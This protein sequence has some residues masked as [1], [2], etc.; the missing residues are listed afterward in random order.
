MTC[1]YLTRLTSA[2]VFLSA[3]ITFTAVRTAAAVEGGAILKNGDFESVQDAKPGSDGLVT[4]WRLGSP[5]QMPTGWQLNAAY[6]GQLAIGVD[7][8]HSGS[9]FVRITA[10]PSGTAHLYQM[11][12]GLQAGKWYRVSLWARGGAF[13]VQTY[14]YFNQGP[15]GGQVLLQQS[16]G[17][18]WQRFT[19]FYQP[20]GEGYLRSALAISTS[21]GGIIDVDDVA[22]DA[23]ALAEVPA[24]APDL[25]FQNDAAQV[26][27]SASGLLTHLVSRTSGKDYAATNPARPVFT[28]QRAGARIPVSLLTRKGDVLTAQFLDPDINVSLRVVTGKRHFSLEVLRVEPAD[29]DALYVEFPL[30][31][32]ETVGPAFNA[33][34]D[35]EFGASFFGT[36]ANTLCAPT[37]LGN[38]IQ[39][40][41]CGSRRTHGIAG[42]KFSLVATPFADFRSAIM[43]AECAGGLPCPKH[44]DKWVRDSA[45]VRKSYL[46]AADA[47]EANIDTLIDYAKLGGFGTI[48]FHKDNWLKTHGH[49]QIN[50]DNFPHG[51]DGVKAAVAK[52]HAAGLEAGV[53]VFGP[54]ISS[55]DA[56]ITPKPDDRLAT[57]PGS[58]LAEALDEKTAT[59]TLSATPK[60][61]P[62][63]PSSKAFPGSYLRI[64][65]EIIRYG[66]AE[67]GP[68]F[69]YTNCIRGALGTRAAAHP[70]GSEVQGLLALWGFFLVDP[71]ST[72]ADELAQN[73]ANVF[74]HTDFDMVYFDSVDGINDAYIDHWYYLNRMHLG[75]YRKFKKD[76]LYQTSNGVGWNIEWHIV[77]RAASADGHGDIKG[78]LD[79]RWPGILTMGANFTRPDLGWYYWFKDVR[80]DQ[81]EYVAAKAVGVDGSISLE[82]SRA[83]LE[84]QVQSRQMMDTIHKWEQA[85]RA[86]PFS[87]KIKAKLRE[88]QKDFKLFSGAKGGWQ[89]YRAAYEVPKIVDVLDGQQNTWNIRNDAATDVGLGVE[90]VSGE[91]SVAKAAYNDPGALTIESFENAGEY[92]MNDL[93]QYV[94]FVEG[95]DSTLS[96]T[97]P[98]RTGVTQNFEVSKG[99]AKVGASALIYSA[100]NKGDIGGW[101]AIGRRFAKPL[102]LRGYKGL[103]LWVRGDANFEQFRIQLRDSHGHNVGF[104]FAI[105]VAGWRLLTFPFPAETQFDWANTEYLLFLFDSVPARTAVSVVLD[106]VRAFR[107]LPPAPLPLGRPIITL[108][109]RTTIFP[110]SMA[111]GQTLTAEGP[112]GVILW[113][114]GMASG[115]M[116]AGATTPL[117]LK[118]GENTV[119]FSTAT[120][121]TFPGGVRIL[122]YRIWP[123]ESN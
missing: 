112:G 14:E 88:P 74:N 76:V 116:V 61:P 82:T 9:R 2:I 86:D 53:H 41:R 91:M 111:G 44:A 35:Q 106:S 99:D 8:P 33:T 38:S 69:R 27:L 43:E 21:G 79:Q 23:L 105:D 10:H 78:Y 50:T 97:G 24:K 36:T 64:G 94:K 1:Q 58:P 84:S 19:V 117:M 121:Q 59:L 120:P 55:N 80:P 100:V 67:P 77:P 22:V 52:I 114:G 56:Y 81:L 4:G 6:P 46:F 122:L 71:D 39:S 3:F 93:N 103:G 60:L 18:Q 13:V 95:D 20:G 15:I 16:A 54:S 110:V 11:C 29:L 37:A 98:V 107:T 90:I 83:A 62:N 63:G 7:G 47:S 49:Y 123:M 34:Y 75:Y 65:D 48:I 70:A 45:S 115:Q 96:S 42:S 12:Q 118:P 66:Q 26:S 31:R 109:G 89:L 102:D 32:L 108:N 25:L 51:L 85:R 92:Q 40:L 119:T 101:S 73:F 28:A 5:A 87:P 30:M 68:P 17:D 104:Q 57:V 113:P 72:L